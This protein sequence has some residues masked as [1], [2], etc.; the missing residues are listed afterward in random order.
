VATLFPDRALEFDPVACRIVNH[1]QAD[2]IIRPPYREG[3]KL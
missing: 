1:K 3:W 2:E